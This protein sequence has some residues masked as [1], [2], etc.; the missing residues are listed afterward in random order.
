MYS[1]DELFDTAIESLK[2]LSQRKVKDIVIRQSEDEEG[3][4]TFRVDVNYKNNSSW[5][6]TKEGGTWT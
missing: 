6:N 4:A 2:R 5:V 3:N 1:N